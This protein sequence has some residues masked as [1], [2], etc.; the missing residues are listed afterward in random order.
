M[1]TEKELNYRFYMHRQEGFVYTSYDQEFSRYRAISSGD[2]ETVRKQLV[3]MK[4]RF[5]KGSFQSGKGV[6]SDDPVRNIRYHMIVSVAVISR[7][8][9]EN[10][11]PQDVAYNLSDIYIR[12]ADSCNSEEAIIDMMAEMQTDFAE[13]MRDIRRSNGVVSGRI[14][15]CV[16]YI[17]EHLG[18]KLT[19]EKTAAYLGIDP[20][21]LSKL[22]VRETGV[23]WRRFIIAARVNIARNMLMY[24]DFSTTDIALSLGF[25]SQSAF[26]AAFR[27]ETGCT[28]AV[29]RKE[30]K[31][32]VL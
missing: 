31:E 5:K 29:F 28:P 25:S 9:V 14:R 11:M 30:H 16:D 12:R 8:C 4:E 19:I 21:Y 7:I 27:E 23:T 15:K 24:S 18:D 22:F 2:V 10:G 13:R 17:Y 32:K 3:G 20:S 6:L 26:I 1:S